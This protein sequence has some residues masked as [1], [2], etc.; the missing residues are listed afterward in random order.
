MVK[1]QNVIIEALD[2]EGG[3]IRFELVG[4]NLP[5]RFQPGGEIHELNAIRLHEGNP[6][7]RIQMTDGRSTGTFSLGGVE[8]M[9]ASYT[10]PPRPKPRFTVGQKVKLH[11]DITPPGVPHRSKGWVGEV[12]EVYWAQMQGVWQYDLKARD[13]KN[14]LTLTDAKD[15]DK[16]AEVVEHWPL[17]RG[18]F[19]TFHPRVGLGT[20]NT[21]KLLDPVTPDHD[22]YH[23]GKPAHWLATEEGPTGTYA[24]DD[25][26][27][28][29]EVRVTKRETWE[30]G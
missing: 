21:F 3:R 26:V 16:G 14:G 10:P 28:P 30:R 18:D 29:V 17:R 15:L 1:V 25:Q 11:P 6:T 24:F 9:E 22:D 27:V 20:N 12:T 19:V 2:A 13:G 7:A 4:D 5:M 8:L 23:H